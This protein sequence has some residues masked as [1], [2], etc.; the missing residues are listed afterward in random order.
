MI[1]ILDQK[2]EV[3]HIQNE[4][5]PKV[6]QGNG[7]PWK[8]NPQVCSENP[9]LKVLIHRKTIKILEAVIQQENKRNPNPLEFIINTAKISREKAEKYIT[10]LIALA[11]LL[12]C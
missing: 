8:F 5:A 12:K 3:G 2:Q 6:Q 7:M 11:S 1:L 4:D 9:N 10:K